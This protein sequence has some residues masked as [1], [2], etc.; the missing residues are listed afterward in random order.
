[1]ASAEPAAAPAFERLVL[2][3]GV[4]AF[5]DAAVRWL[6]DR[7]P[8]ARLRFAPLQGT[9]AE[10]LRARHPE[11]PRDIDTLVF[12]EAADE[13]ERVYLRS[14]AIFRV[15]GQLEPERGMLRLLRRV[16]RPLADL[17]YALFV[18]FRYRVFGRLEA[19]RVPTA[20]ERDRFLD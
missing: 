20:E 1:M 19:C 8:D 9:T 15:W 11:I 10:A 3:D 18:R 2:F 17:G 6:M 12:V 7:D 16:P 5:C 4:C 14:A 13:S